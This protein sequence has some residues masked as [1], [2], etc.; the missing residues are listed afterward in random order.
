MVNAMGSEMVLETYG[1]RADTFTTTDIFCLP[2]PMHAQSGLA[3]Q[4]INVARA[5]CVEEV[6]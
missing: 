3:T 6:D 5:A 4:T 1:D 2:D